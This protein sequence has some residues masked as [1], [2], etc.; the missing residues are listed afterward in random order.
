[1]II[2]NFA[3]KLGE[4]GYGVVY[5]GKVMNDAVVVVK[6]LDRHRHCETQFMNEV[7]TIRRVHHVNS[8][9]L[10]YIFSRFLQAHSYTER[11]DQSD[12]GGRHE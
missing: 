11:R 1:M 12:V 7:V 6:L 10:L 8:I 4:G 9:R 3:E 2:K 5:K